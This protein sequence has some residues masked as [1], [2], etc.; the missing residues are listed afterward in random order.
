MKRSIFTRILGGKLPGSFIYRGERISAFLDVHGVN[1]GHC[2]VVPNEE[3]GS[4]SDLDPEIGKEL[5]HLAHRIAT[6]YRKGVVACAGVNIWVSD[7]EVAGQEV[8][9]VHLHVVPRTSADTLQI[10]YQADDWC[11]AK[12]PAL[13]AVARR[14]RE[15]MDT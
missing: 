8:P 9:H 6:A 13:D 1:E 15:R 11:E 14:I 4:L 2:L 12:R 7:G 10:S 5:F 3:V